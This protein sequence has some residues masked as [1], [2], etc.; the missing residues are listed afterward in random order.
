MRDPARRW[1]VPPAGRALAALAVLSI[2][3]LA[4]CARPAPR[5]PEGVLEGIDFFF[6][7]AE[8]G[9][10]GFEISAADLPLLAGAGFSRFSSL[11]TV[12]VTV[13]EKPDALDAEKE[14]AIAALET[15]IP[16]LEALKDAPAFEFLV[17]DVGEGLFIGADERPGKEKAA[18]ANL[19]RAMARLGISLARA[20]GARKIYYRNWAW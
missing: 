15:G 6:D 2:S 13:T 1:L 20:S 3:A 14:A 18:A 5:P 9:S 11:R 17:L 8:T 16:A 19:S 12:V 4:S 10:A 7:P